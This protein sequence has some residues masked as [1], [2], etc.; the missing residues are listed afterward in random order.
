MQDLNVDIIDVLFIVMATFGF[1]FG[2]TF[3]LLRLALI[4][5]SFLFATLAAMAF[6]PMTTN[7]IMETFA[8]DSVFLPFIA[9]FVTL[10][11]VLMLARIITKLLEETLTSERFDVL[12]RIVGGLLMVIWFSL[13]Y[14]VLVIFFGRAGVL[15][16]VFNEQ[17]IIKPMDGAVRLGILGK[18]VPTGGADT[19]YMK[20]N[21]EQNIYPFT[22]GKT[23]TGVNLSFG[24][25]PEGQDNFNAYISQRGQSWDVL[26]TD[27]VMLWGTNQ[28]IIQKD[29]EMICF[30]DSSFMLHTENNLLIFDCLDEDLSAKSP[31]SRL[32]PYIEQIPKRGT[33]L[34]R[35]FRPFIKDFSEYMSIAVDN[36]KNDRPRPERII[37]TNSEENNKPTV[38]P[39]TEE[40]PDFEP[41]EMDT[42]GFPID[43][44]QMPVVRPPDEA[45]DLPELENIEDDS[46]DYEG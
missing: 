40:E 11:I 16:L 13:L 9:F 7:I 28:L 32:Y 29:K 31:T 5:F 1:Y 38:Q 45:V 30:C 14:S 33:Q 10:L 36:L 34:I 21:A 39:V 44:T 2:F 23:S 19:L 35:G 26:P 46:T 8:V 12:S 6:T 24:F 18:T 42:L 25:V 15:E 41:E 27:T 17:A 37:K 22:T 3:G 4:L 43:T 20:Y